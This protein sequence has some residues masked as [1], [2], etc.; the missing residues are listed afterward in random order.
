LVQTTNSDIWV[1]TTL[2]VATRFA[3]RRPY[4][5]PKLQLNFQLRSAFGCNLICNSS[6]LYTSPGYNLIYN[7]SILYTSP[8]ATQSATV[9]HLV[10]QLHLQLSYCIY[11]PICKLSCNW[12]ATSVTS[13]IAT[14]SCKPS[15][16][17]NSSCN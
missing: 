16:S 5:T 15:L 14:Q 7:S 17:C 9:T 4:I 12:E 2:R 11:L 6:I 13:Q 3:T 1:L 10:L 8:I